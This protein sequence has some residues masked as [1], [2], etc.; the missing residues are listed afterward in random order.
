M[1]ATHKLRLKV[2]PGEIRHGLAAPDRATCCGLR[3]APEC[4]VSDFLFSI[5]YFSFFFAFLFF[6]RFF[7]LP[8]QFSIFKSLRI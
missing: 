6:F 5:F 3:A 7:V 1:R 4:R 8:I 2:A